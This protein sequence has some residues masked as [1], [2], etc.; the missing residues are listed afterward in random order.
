[1]FN[2]MAVAAHASSSHNRRWCIRSHSR[3]KVTTVAT[4]G[5]TRLTTVDSSVPALVS[6]KFSTSLPSVCWTV[7]PPGDDMLTSGKNT[8][9]RPLYPVFDILSVGPTDILGYSLFNVSIDFRT[10]LWSNAYITFLTVLSCA[11]R[12]TVIINHTPKQVCY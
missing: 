12:I 6:K 10:G 5:T 4:M 2:T 1:M 9:V 8:Q 11:I 7:G 3:N